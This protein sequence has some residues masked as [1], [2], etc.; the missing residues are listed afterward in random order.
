MVFKFWK[1]IKNSS[2]VKSNKDN[3]EKLEK[4]RREYE[5]KAQCLQNFMNIPTLTQMSRACAA[6]EKDSNPG[7]L[8]CRKNK[9]FVPNGKY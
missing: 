8:D 4:I 9:R 2:T 3:E 7:K 5:I 1:G 6:L